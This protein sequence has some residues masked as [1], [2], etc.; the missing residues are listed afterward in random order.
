MRKAHIIQ[1]SQHHTECLIYYLS[2]TDFILFSSETLELKYSICLQVVVG[3]SCFL[4]PGGGHQWPTLGMQSL[5]IWR[6]CL[7]HLIPSTAFR[8][9]YLLVQV[10]VGN[11]I[12]P[13]HATYLT[14]TPIME[15][16]DLIFSISIFSLVNTHQLSESCSR[17][18]L[19]LLL[20]SRGCAAWI[21]GCFEH[22]WMC[23]ILT[24]LLHKLSFLRSCPRYVNLSS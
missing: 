23:C 14:E 5:S 18:D 13:K 20:C 9:I 17:T 6:T 1:T 11:R 10:L 16:S 4:F 12:Q 21:H 24:S 19:A 7:S 3:F 8:A 22:L 15:R 2:L